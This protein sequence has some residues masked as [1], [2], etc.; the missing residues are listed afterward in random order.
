MPVAN[1]E[2]NDGLLGVLFSEDMILSDTSDLRVRSL[3]SSE[4][5]QNVKVL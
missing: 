5:T 2:A 4:S 3:S 1:V